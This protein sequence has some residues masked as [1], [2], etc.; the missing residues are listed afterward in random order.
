MPSRTA[1][2]LRRSLALAAAGLVAR[3][4]APARAEPP[5]D[6]A[7]APA[8]DADLVVRYWSAIEPRLPRWRVDGTVE[9][10]GGDAGAVESRAA[11]GRSFLAGPDLGGALAITYDRWDLAGAA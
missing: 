5:P 7:A 6:P 1:P 11:I 2:V 10:I 9:L 8:V 4:G 3:L